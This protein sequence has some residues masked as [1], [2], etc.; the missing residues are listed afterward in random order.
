M[1]K[2]RPWAVKPLVQDHTTRYLQTVK[3]PRLLHYLPL[4]FLLKHNAVLSFEYLCMLINTQMCHSKIK[5]I[6]SVK[7]ADFSC[8]D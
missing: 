5:A 3:E 8:L 1:N 2:Q 6:G 4:L 7:T